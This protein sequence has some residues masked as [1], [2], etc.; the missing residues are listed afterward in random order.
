MVGKNKEIMYT[1]STFKTLDEI[2]MMSITDI[3][4][5]PM[6]GFNSAKEADTGVY[7]TNRGDIVGVMLTQEQYEKLVTDLRDLKEQVQFI[8]NEK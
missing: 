1:E 5:A 3:K 2:P 7:I 4:E 8:I 6:K